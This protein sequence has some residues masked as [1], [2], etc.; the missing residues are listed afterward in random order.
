MVTFIY[1]RRLFFLL[2]LITVLVSNVSAQYTTDGF[3]RVQNFGTKRYLY[4]TDNAGSYDM[5]RD[6][7]D[8][9]ALQLYTGAEK[10]ISDPSCI[11]YIKKYG[12]QIDIQ[13]QGSGIYQFV[14]RYVD[15]KSVSSGAYKG[16]LQS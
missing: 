9:G 13:G 15:L 4:L 12:S 5:K 2:G 8:F 10:T 11:F 7:G 3:Y 16:R 14:N 6:V 1:M